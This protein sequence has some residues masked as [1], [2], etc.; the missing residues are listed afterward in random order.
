M[1]GPFRALYVEYWRPLMVG[2]LAFFFP[3][4]QKPCLNV[5]LC[6]IGITLLLPLFLLVLGLCYLVALAG[7]GFSPVVREI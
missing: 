7:T 3:R 4:K 2:S 6:H 1:C 5:L